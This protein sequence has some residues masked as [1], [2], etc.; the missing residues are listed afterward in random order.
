MESVLHA[1]NQGRCDWGAARY[2]LLACRNLLKPAPTLAGLCPAPGTPLADGARVVGSW[3]GMAVLAR[4]YPVAKGGPLGWEVSSLWRERG[5][6][7]GLVRST[8]GHH[9]R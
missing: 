3:R 6:E 1:A 8:D 2:L 4:P 9:H 7:P 5:W